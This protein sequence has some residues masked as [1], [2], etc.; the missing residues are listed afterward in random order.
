MINLAN[1]RDLR[2][3]RR[4]LR[5]STQDSELAI[6]CCTIA[7]L[8]TSPHECARARDLLHL[9]TGELGAAA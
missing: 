1:I 2:R 7:R 4:T 3:A 8:S 9:I 6:A 5:S